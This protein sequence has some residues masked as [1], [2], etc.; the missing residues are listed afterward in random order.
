[1]ITEPPA[2]GQ[3]TP[4]QDIETLYIGDAEPA[5]VRQVRVG[6]TGQIK[7][8]RDCEGSLTTTMARTSSRTSWGRVQ[9][10]KHEVE[11]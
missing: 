11:R 9:W 4:L 7:T 8:M 10:N 1:M 3:R 6:P 2:D 5:V